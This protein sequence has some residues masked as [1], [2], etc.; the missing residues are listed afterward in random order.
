MARIFFGQPKGS[1]AW[2][3]PGI[4]YWR[5]AIGWASTMTIL[6]SLTSIALAATAVDIW[7]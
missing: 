7:W 5:E 2:F 1:A 4:Y 3:K 6:I